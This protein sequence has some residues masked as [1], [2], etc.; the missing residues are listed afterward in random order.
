MSIFKLLTYTK[1]HCVALKYTD[2]FFFQAHI[3]VSLNYLVPAA[4]ILGN[5]QRWHCVDTEGIG[6]AKY[7]KNCKN[8]SRL[9]I[10][11]LDEFVDAIMFSPSLTNAQLERVAFQYNLS[12]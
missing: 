2:T 5:I 8:K 9:H 6:A 12:L 3:Y 1:V 10:G 11:L 7:H 4:K